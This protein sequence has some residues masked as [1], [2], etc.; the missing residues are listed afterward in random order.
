MS[1]YKSSATRRYGTLAS[2]ASCAIAAGGC[3]SDRAQSQC[4]ADVSPVGYD[5]VVN[6]IPNARID[7]LINGQRKSLVTK[8]GN[9]KIGST[10]DEVEIVRCRSGQ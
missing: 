1:S 2:L 8:T 9:E 7:Y 4:E 3:A 5:L 6:T 10:A